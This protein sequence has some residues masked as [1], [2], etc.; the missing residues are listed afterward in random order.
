MAELAPKEN[1][2]GAEL[3]QGESVH[4]KLHHCGGHIDRERS[5]TLFGHQQAPAIMPGSGIVREIFAGAIQRER[6]QISL[7]AL[8]NEHIEISHGHHSRKGETAR[9]GERLAQLASALR[10]IGQPKHT[11]RRCSTPRSRSYGIGL[12]RWHTYGA[13]GGPAVGQNE[14]QQ[15]NVSSMPCAP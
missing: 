12:T 1:D 3:N 11:A 2:P 4:P 5:E 14:L 9:V 10:E 13:P 15:R 6:I 8:K 7:R